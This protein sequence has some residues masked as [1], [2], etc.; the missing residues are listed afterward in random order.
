[1][2]TTKANEIL[3]QYWDET[4]PV[5]PVVIAN[6]MGIA[7]MADPYLGTES[8]HYLPR[9]SETGNPLVVYNPREAYVRQRFTVAHELGHHALNHGDSP[10]DTS[11]NFT[12][13]ANDRREVAAN[14]FA[15][16]L[17]MPAE[18]V[19]ALIK[20][21]GIRTIEQLASMFNVSKAAMTYR[22]GNLGYVVN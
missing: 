3:K 1:M 4:I 17:L 11:A 8:G 16:E 6:R 14:C 2:P 21:R 15:A 13:G 5:D 20:V 18:I 7:V 19:H 12:M 9:G 22:V 10:R